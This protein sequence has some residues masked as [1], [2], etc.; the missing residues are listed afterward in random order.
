MIAAAADTR[1]FQLTIDELRAAS[2]LV[3]RAVPPTPQ[4]R[5]PLLSARLG[6]D[7]FVKHEN[8]TPTGAFKVRGGVVYI[9][10][11]VRRDPGCAGV[12]TATRG[13]HGQSV[14]RAATRAGLSATVVVPS[15]NS[16]EKNAATVAFGAE[17]IEAGDDFQSASEAARALAVERGLH[18]IGPFHPEL[19]LGVASSSLEL[20]DAVHD[21]DVLYVPIGMGSGICAAI[22]TRDALGLDTEIVGV[23]SSHAPACAR[24]LEAGRIVEAPA[25]TELADG[26]ACR[27][28]DPRALAIIAAGAT[29]VVEVTDDQVAEAMRNYFS[30]THNVAEGAGAAPLAAALDE[31]ERI[32]GRRVALVLSGGNVDSGVFARVLAT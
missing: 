4:H 6:A 20:F 11:L 5:W 27:T 24:S 23:C 14:A 3:A 30:D 12:V 29:R 28:P 32:G 22:A 26:V 17:L 2:E 15:G 19:V 18:P 7:V 31:R 21:I 25:T 9:D 16:V 10:E 8:H 13:N 1:A